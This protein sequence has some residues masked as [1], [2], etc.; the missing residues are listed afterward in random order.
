MGHLLFLRERQKHAK[1]SAISDNF[2]LWSQMSME[3]NNNDNGNANWNL[4]H[5]IYDDAIWPANKKVAESAKSVFIFP[6]RV[7][8]GRTEDAVRVQRGASS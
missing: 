1:F 4:F 5:V 2:R 7:F 3:G 8:A 6:F